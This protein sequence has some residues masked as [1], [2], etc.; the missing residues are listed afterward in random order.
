MPRTHHLF[1]RGTTWTWRRRIPS[2][3][4]EITHLQISLRS[5]NLS[6]ARM[7]ANRLDYESDRIMQ[8]IATGGL[9]PQEGRLYLDA[10]CRNELQRIQRQRLITRMDAVIGD[11]DID[12]RLDW[13]TR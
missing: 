11:D 3:S 5:K 8:A 10:V 12:R 7:L 6:I 1:L 13:A 9:T 2:Q 4:T